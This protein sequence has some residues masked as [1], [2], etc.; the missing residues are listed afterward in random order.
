MTDRTQKLILT[1]DDDAATRKYFKTILEE[2]N[3]KVIE[4]VNEHGMTMVF[5]TK[6]H[7]RH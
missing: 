3:Y 1:I 4:A 7:F 2:N 6:R 5:T